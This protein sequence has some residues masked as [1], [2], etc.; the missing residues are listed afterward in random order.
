MGLATDLQTEVASIFANRW[1]E[2]EGQDVPDP[3]KLKLGNDAVTLD[4][5][6][7]Y[8]DMAS[9]TILVQDHT[10]S[11]AAEV[12]KSYMVCAVRVIKSLGGTITAY[13]GDRVMGIFIGDY[14]NTNAAKAALKI[15][16]VVVH[17]INPSIA[18]QYGSG[19]Y[20]MD[21]VI[22][23]D[24]SSILAARIGVRN[25]NDIV[26]V[27]RAANYAAKLTEL[28]KAQIYITD[29]V[30]KKLN[31]EAKLGPSN[32]PMWEARNWTTMNMRIHRSNWTWTID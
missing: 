2:R 17:L 21:H 16:W 32:E 27:G 12:Y 14:K 26:W 30:F 8:A 5:T 13:D 15:N 25:D 4:A 24:T 11:F 22:G 1:S 18:S 10:P 20:Q 7:L 28:D 31:G 6:V 23:I 19:S 3:T 29:D 9:S